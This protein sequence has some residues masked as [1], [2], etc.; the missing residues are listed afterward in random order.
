MQNQN[1]NQKAQT[2]I[3]PVS[4]LHYISPYGLIAAD[5]HSNMNPVDDEIKNTTIYSYRNWVDFKEDERLN[6]YLP[7]LLSSLV[8]SVSHPTY[9]DLLRIC[10]FHICPMSKD[11]KAMM[12]IIGIPGSLLQIEQ[13]Y[14]AF[15]QL[16]GD[17]YFL[18]FRLH[19]ENFLMYLRHQ[20]Q[21]DQD[22]KN[23]HQDQRN[24][25]EEEKSVL[26]AHDNPIQLFYYDGHT[27]IPISLMSCHSYFSQ[28]RLKQSDVVIDSTAQRSWIFHYEDV[29]IKNHLYEPND[30][31]LKQP[32]KPMKKRN[33]GFAVVQIQSSS[34]TSCQFVQFVHSD[35]MTLISNDSWSKFCIFEKQRWL[36][37]VTSCYK[38]SEQHVYMEIIQLDPPFTILYLFRIQFHLDDSSFDMQ[39]FDLSVTEETEQLWITHIEIMNHEIKYV[40]TSVSLKII[41]LQ[42]EQQEQKLNLP[43]LHLFILHT[44][45]AHPKLISDRLPE[46][47]V[48]H[49]KVVTWPLEA[50][51]TLTHKKQLALMLLTEPHSL[52]YE[53]H[54]NDLKCSVTWYVFPMVSVSSSTSVN[55]LYKVDFETIYHQLSIHVE[56][57]R[58]YTK[59]EFQNQ[60]L[61]LIERETQPHNK[62]IQ[63]E[64]GISEYDKSYK[65]VFH[66][67]ADRKTNLRLNPLLELLTE[68]DHHESNL[69]SSQY[70]HYKTSVFSCSNPCRKA[71]YQSLPD[72]FTK[73]SIFE[74]AL[75][76]LL[77]SYVSCW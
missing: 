74:P 27:N 54:L 68:F 48:I 8:S 70:I 33:Q 72:Y 76:N 25:Q 71:W 56:N 23:Q 73:H 19:Q 3:R 38:D 57:W 47:V 58:R 67:A 30:N 17:D 46:Q 43:I 13:V 35:V 29:A 15:L 24:H 75:I 50:Q 62:I 20:K 10:E 61:V 37:H 7:D 77:W 63:N 1:Q 2:K 49:S 41:D 21:Q 34:F 11:T 28:K 45:A 32:W 69:D 59:A 22:Q 4:V 18:G 5:D 44:F 14:L 39:Y 65:P 16:M 51:Y 66:L 64:Y 6:Q 42:Q 9:Y 36:I 12:I 26:I 31:D 53:Y 52:S 55:M 40:C 60:Y